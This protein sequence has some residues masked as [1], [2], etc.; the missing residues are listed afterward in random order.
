MDTARCRLAAEVLLLMLNDRE[1]DLGELGRE[2][3]R[4]RDVLRALLAESVPAGEPILWV[5]MKRGYVDW[6]ENCV[7]PTR[8]DLQY[9]EE[10]SEIAVP[11]YAAPS[12]PAGWISVKSQ[13]PESDVPVL[14][15]YRAQYKPRKTNLDGTRWSIITARH[16]GGEWRF[17][18][19]NQKSRLPERII[20]WMPLPAAPDNGQEEER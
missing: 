4:Y 11:L 20:Y 19:K 16:A 9:R 7:S 14:V 13:L 17:L 2:C 12:V 5:R 1:V 18:T 3:W 6:D 10:A 8:D 15:A